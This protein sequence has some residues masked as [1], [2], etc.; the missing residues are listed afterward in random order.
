MSDNLPMVNEG[1]DVALVADGANIA[2]MLQGLVQSLSRQTESFD[3]VECSLHCESSPD[4][5]SR[6][7]FNFR[8]YK[9]RAA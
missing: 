6:S 8:A 7:V 5:A 2:P 4:G 1:R 9:H 3:G